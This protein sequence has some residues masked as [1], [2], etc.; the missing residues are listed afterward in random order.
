MAS[1]HSISSER[2]SANADVKNSEGIIIIIL[3]ILT[4]DER[5]C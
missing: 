3:I 4:V 5:I 1:C 2:L